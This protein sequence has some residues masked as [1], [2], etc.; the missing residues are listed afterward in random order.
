MRASE[1]GDLAAELGADGAAGAGD[2]HPLAGQ[3]VRRL[4]WRSSSTGS[5]ASSSSMLMSRIGIRVRPS[6]LGQLDDGLG[7]R[8]RRMPSFLRLA[9]PVGGQSP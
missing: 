2:Q 7:R 6:W 5:R 3:Q 8:N 1:G 4:A 9:E